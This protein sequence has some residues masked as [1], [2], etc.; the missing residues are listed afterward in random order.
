VI[1][2][3]VDVVSRNGNLMLNFPLPNSG[4]LDDRELAILD[5]I[6]KW[7][8]V[9][10]E[11][12]HATRPWKIFGEGPGTQASATPGSFNEG[13]RKDLTIADVRFTTQG[14]AL[15]AFVM[16]W[17]EPQTPQ[18]VV[19]TPLGTENLHGRINNV[20]LLGHPGKL[21]WTQGAVALRIKLPFEKPCDHAIA[22]RISGLA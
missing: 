18:E 9:N 3:L 5:E 15:Y 13:K 1:D 16:G 21:E 10:G 2:L 14:S 17:P 19:I 8:S 11:A 22:F 20:E 12:I 4:M 6:T 7:M